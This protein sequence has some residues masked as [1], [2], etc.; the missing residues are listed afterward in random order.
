VVHSDLSA[1]EIG[2]SGGSGVSAGLADSWGYSGCTAVSIAGV[3]VVIVI[4][5]LVI[6][7]LFREGAFILILLV[8][9][10]GLL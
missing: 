1:P 7:F 8:L 2:G 9:V 3:A 10:A 6:T 5:V 4:A